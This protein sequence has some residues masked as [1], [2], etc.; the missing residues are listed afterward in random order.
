VTCH[1]GTAVTAV[2]PSGEEVRLETVGSGMPAADIVVGADGY[3]SLVR[4]PGQ[5]VR[6]AQPGPNRAPSR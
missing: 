3:R 6:P 1:D 2:V 4:R 5:P